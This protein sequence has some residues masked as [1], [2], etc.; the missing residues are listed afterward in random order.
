PKGDPG[1]TLSRDELADKFRRLLAFSGAA[2]DAEAEILIQRAWGLRQA[3]SV[4]PLI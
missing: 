3:P 2:T 1:N 4:T